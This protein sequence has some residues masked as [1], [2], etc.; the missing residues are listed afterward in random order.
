MNGSV[1]VQLSFQ[2][3]M[4]FYDS[5]EEFCLTQTPSKSYQDTQSASYGGDVVDNYENNENGGLV[6]LEYSSQS[7]NFGFGLSL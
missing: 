7:A 3:V 1:C 2:L 4:D 5:E 6:S